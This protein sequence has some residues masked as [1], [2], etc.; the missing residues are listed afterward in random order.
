MNKNGDPSQFQGRIVF[1]S[2]FNDI[3]WGSTDNERG[4][5]ANATLVTNLQKKISSRTLVIPRTWVR[6]EVV[7]YL[8][9]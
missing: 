4:C 3:M 8:H 7:F 5:I 6:K 9:R 2:V 1:M